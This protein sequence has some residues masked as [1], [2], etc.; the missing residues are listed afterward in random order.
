MVSRP[1]LLST[2]LTV[3]Q[4][5]VGAGEE[6]CVCERVGACVRCVCVWGVGGL[7]SSSALKIKVQLAAT[8]PSSFLSAVPAPLQ[9]LPGPSRIHFH[10]TSTT[11]SHQILRHMAPC[12]GV[13]VTGSYPPPDSITMT[14]AADQMET[15]LLIRLQFRF[16]CTGGWG[17]G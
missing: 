11:T 5:C 12:V 13:N 6:G 8:C 2:N 14:T 4:L 7:I 10:I 16:K 1:D 15:S 3:V 17:G 9:D